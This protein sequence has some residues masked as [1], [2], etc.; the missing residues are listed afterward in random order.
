MKSKVSLPCL[1]EANTGLYPV[2]DK[3]SPQLSTLIL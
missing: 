2:P 3:S 1:L